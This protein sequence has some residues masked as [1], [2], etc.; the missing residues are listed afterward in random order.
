MGG[1]LGPHI[2]EAMVKVPLD[3]M[4][5]WTV[6]KL[7]P[8]KES[9][10]I[11]G[12]MVSSVADASKAHAIAQ[13]KQSENS[14]EMISLIREM[15]TD[16]RRLHQDKLSQAGE[17]I[18][19]LSKELESAE[20][21]ERALLPYHD[22]FAIIDAELE[23][24]LLDRISP[25]LSEV[26]RPVERSADSLYISSENAGDKIAYIDRFTLQR[27]NGDLIDPLPTAMQGDIIRY[28]K[29]TG[30]GKFKNSEF[31]KDVS[32]VVPSA[33]KNSVNWDVIDAMKSASVEAVF[34]MVKTKRSVIKHLIF[35]DVDTVLE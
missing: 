12:K 9:M 10:E 27:L 31:P 5:A 29:E 28:D 35:D 30:W 15:Y 34:Y 18:R 14:S 33:K 32:F 26:A 13:A 21:R 6:G 1:I 25:L 7:T 20:K 8:K 23:K 16:S 19:S 11:A 4:V 2:S 17:Q 24:K 22:A 3:V